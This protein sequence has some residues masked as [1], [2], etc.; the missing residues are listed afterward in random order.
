MLKIPRNFT[1]SLL[2]I[3][4][5]LGPPARRHVTVKNFLEKSHIPTCVWHTA[6]TAE[7]FEVGAYITN[8]ELEHVQ[9]TGFQS[10]SAWKRNVSSSSRPYGCPHELD[11]WVTG[12][13]DHPSITK[14]HRLPTPASYLCVPRLPWW[15]FHPG[16]NQLHYVLTNR[17]TSNFPLL[18]SLWCLFGLLARIV[19]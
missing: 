11:L 12:L 6:K 1:P 15:K 8:T 17:T 5:I 9:E 3:V 18:A 16:T 7:R 19:G 14:S 10:I 13:R 4:L 2:W